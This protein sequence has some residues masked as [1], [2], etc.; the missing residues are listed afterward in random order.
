MKIEKQGR[1]TW[2]VDFSDEIRDTQQPLT[3]ANGKEKDCGCGEGCGCDETEGAE[4]FGGKKRSALKDSDFLDPKRRSFPVMSCKDVKDAVS[5]WGMY[6]GSMS[7]EQF[8]EKLTRRAKKLGCET[9]LP[10]KWKGES[11]SAQKTKKE[12]DKID[13]KEL[14]RDTKKEKVQH[15]KDALKDDKEKIKKL[16][17]GKPSEKKN[18]EIHDIKKDEQYD[19]KNKKKYSKGESYRHQQETLEHKEGLQDAWE[20][21]R[22]SRLQKIKHHQDAIKNL[23]Q[24]IQQLEKDRREDLKDVNF[25]KK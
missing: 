18:I 11:K 15:E 6:K 23:Q 24:E 25:E 9:S 3:V 8:K 10:A 21:A 17:K 5:A 1:D 2:E 7:F 14:K 22:D 12:W 20:L 19:K 16:K 13:E 4:R